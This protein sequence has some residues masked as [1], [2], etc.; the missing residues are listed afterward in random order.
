MINDTVDLILKNF[1]PLIDIVK[2]DVENES[3]LPIPVFCIKDI[4]KL[5][6]ESIKI[7]HDCSI[8]PRISDTCYVIGDIHGNLYD[9]I[10]IWINMCKEPSHIVFL[11][12]YVDRG[13]NSLEVVVFLL[14]LLVKYPDRITLLRGNHEFECIN[15]NHGFKTE[16]MNKMKNDD[17][18]YS[19]NRVFDWLPIACTINNSGFC[20]HGGISPFLERIESLYLFKRPI[21]NF[22][23]QIL[24][25]LLWSDPTVLDSDF[26]FS[27]R[28]I[29]YDYGLK[30]ISRFLKSNGLSYILRAHQCVECGVKSFGNGKLFTIFSSSNYLNGNNV[31]GIIHIDQDGKIEKYFLKPI[32]E[33]LLLNK[34]YFNANTNIIPW[35][36]TNTY[37]SL[38]N[39]FCLVK[40]HSQK[41]ISL[42]KLQK[43]AQKRRKSIY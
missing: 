10:R 41:A 36:S 23:N 34:R 4:E 32:S 18:F 11:G 21:T 16:V 26:I 19:I 14:A 33:F 35:D 5:C 24:E 17:A 8:F 38:K 15:S 31:S 27:E 9:T 1:L 22:N 13:E 40:K 6:V 12:D 28:G 7:L 39:K 25:G 43:I 42:P 37:K 30:A 3:E 2:N 29:T 20:V